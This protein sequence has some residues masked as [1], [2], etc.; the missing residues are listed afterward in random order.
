MSLA[1]PQLSI[2]NGAPFRVGIAAACYNPRLVDGLLERVCAA[3]EGAGVKARNLTI[4]RVPGSNEVPYAASLLARRRPDAIIALGVLIRGDTL[5]YELIADAVS[6]GLQEVA[7]STGRP[8]ING[9]I[10]AENPAQAEA[11]CLG[12]IDRG[13][14]FARAALAMAALRRRFVR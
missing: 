9:V 6:H 13:A 5:H 7:L 12:R 2:P 4:A 1:A 3:L 10:V 11:R 14:E 8:V